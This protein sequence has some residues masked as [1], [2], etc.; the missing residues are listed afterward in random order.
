MARGDE[1]MEMETGNKKMSSRTELTL[2]REHLREHRRMIIG[3]ALAA[4]MI[5]AV[6]VPVL[7]DKLTFIVQR[8]TLRRLAR[9]HQVDLDADAIQNL[10]YGEVSA[11]SWSE[12]TSST[13]V[14]RFLTRTWRKLVVVYLTARRVQ[15]AGRYFLEAT[16]FDHY[17]AKLH[18]G[19]GLDADSAMAVR[20]AM[21]QALSSTPGSLGTRMFRRGALAAARATVRAPLELMHIASRGALRKLMSRNQSEE[22]EAVEELDMALERQMLAHKSFLAR[23][24]TAVELQLSVEANPYIDRLVDN[25]ELLWRLRRKPGF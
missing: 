5:G 8:G 21:D 11:P 6:P 2:Q 1:E 24:A 3:R 4:A 23:A 22:A 12:T 15:A 20:K 25:F 16:L 19:P 13:L 7:D 9:H 14:F 10:V 17:C 18:V